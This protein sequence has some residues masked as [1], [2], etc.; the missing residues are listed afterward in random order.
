MFEMETLLRLPRGQVKL[1]LRGM[2]SLVSF[3]T[4]PVDVHYWSEP[5]ILWVFPSR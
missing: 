1:M 3:E 5:R 4:P 2:R